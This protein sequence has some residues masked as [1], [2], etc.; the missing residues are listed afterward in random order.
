MLLH[1]ALVHSRFSGCSSIYLEGGCFSSRSIP[2]SLLDYEPPCN[3]TGNMTLRD[4][5]KGLGMIIPYR[6]FRRDHEWYELGWHSYVDCS[7]YHCYMCGLVKLSGTCPLVGNLRC[8]SRF[9]SPRYLCG[10]S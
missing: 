10:G 4:C 9:A 6:R 1:M 5:S 3:V 2:T 7:L 8:A